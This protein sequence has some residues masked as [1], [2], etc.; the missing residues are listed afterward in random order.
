MRDGSEGVE[1]VQEGSFGDGDRVE[2]LD[3]GGG[4]KS[5]AEDGGGGAAAKAAGMVKRGSSSAEITVA[6]AAEREWAWGRERK[7]WRSAIN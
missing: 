3:G 4:Q 2:E 6:E 1:L 5:S 7:R